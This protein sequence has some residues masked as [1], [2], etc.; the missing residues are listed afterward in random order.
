MVELIIRCQIKL[1]RD[2]ANH[3]RR[4]IRHSTTTVEL[5]RLLIV[6]RTKTYRRFVMC[7]SKLTRRTYFTCTRAGLR[8][9]VWLVT[10]VTIISLGS[11][12]C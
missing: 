6:P 4:H 1:D 11:A 7:I 9:C 8:V 3:G 2:C 12:A 10:R 5:M